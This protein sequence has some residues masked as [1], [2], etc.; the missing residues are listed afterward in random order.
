MKQAATTEQRSAMKQAATDD[1]VEQ[2]LMM[3]IGAAL[4]SAERFGGFQVQ[5]LSSR[6]EASLIGFLFKLLDGDGLQR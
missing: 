4:N 6:R 3:W 5:P 1:D 2:Q